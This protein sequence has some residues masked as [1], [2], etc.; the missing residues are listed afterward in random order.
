MGIQSIRGKGQ[1]SPLDV[2]VI[3]QL[4]GKLANM[5]SVTNRAIVSSSGFTNSPK[6][7]AE[8]RGIDL[9]TLEKWSKPIDLDFPQ[10]GL[11]GCPKTPYPSSN[12]FFAGMG[13]NLT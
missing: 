4:C 1:K 12:H 9:Y 11:K 5:S 13:G 8:Q 6:R 3:E 10:F 2:T 7:K